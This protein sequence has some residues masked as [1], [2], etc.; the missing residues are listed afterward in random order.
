MLDKLASKEK[1][2]HWS[3]E[4]DTDEAVEGKVEKK[5]EVEGMM[6]KV[7][8]LVEAEEVVDWI[9]Q[10]EEEEK[11]LWLEDLNKEDVILG[12]V[13]KLEEKVMNGAL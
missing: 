6:G 7:G 5:K 3:E 9:E 1:L 11:V 2:G 12:W 10:L 4:F 8:G 13:G